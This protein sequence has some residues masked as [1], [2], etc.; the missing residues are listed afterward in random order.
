MRKSTWVGVVL[1]TV[2]A[3]AVAAC[4]GDDEGD[5]EGNKAES[6]EIACE[7][8][9]L[10][11]DTGLPGSFPTP[12]GA[13]YVK[14]EQNGPTRVVNGYY[15]GDLQAAYEDYK[16]AF[17]SAGYE[18]LFDELEEDDSEVSYR[19]DEGKTEGLVALKA[20]CREEDTISIRITSRPAQE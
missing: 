5:N 1:V 16:G 12:D 4:G 19:D 14:T 11:R 20:E 7:G 13:T 18:L 3:F 8:P 10:S 15:E 9:A 17:E 2:A 6:A